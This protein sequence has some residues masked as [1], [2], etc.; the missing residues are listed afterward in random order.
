MN[1]DNDGD[2]Q[3][4]W[5]QAEEADGVHA[6]IMSFPS[7]RKLLGDRQQEDTWWTQ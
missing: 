2:G 3:Q 4:M 5:A 7:Q 1:I 6:D